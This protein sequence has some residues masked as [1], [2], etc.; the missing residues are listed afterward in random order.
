MDLLR[1]EHIC[2]IKMKRLTI[3]CS[4]LACAFLLSAC[5][6]SKSW[7]DTCKSVLQ[8]VGDGLID[9]GKALKE[10]QPSEKDAPADDKT[11]EDAFRDV[12]QGVE[13]GLSDL[14][15]MFHEDSPAQ[16]GPPA[17]DTICCNIGRLPTSRS[18]RSGK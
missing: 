2:N 10:G 3:I 8:N 16:N 1:V 5:S 14:Y 12:F 6:A 17:D 15:K 11:W 9:I 4:I 13:S 7:E 18:H